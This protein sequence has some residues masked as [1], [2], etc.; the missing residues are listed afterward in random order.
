MKLTNYM[1]SVLFK[2]YAFLVYCIPMAILFFC[3]VNAYTSN[4]KLSFFGILIIGFIVIAFANTLKKIFKYNIGLS[5]SAVMF[6]V[7]L[8]SKFLGEQLILI[9]GASFVGSVLSM[10]VG[11]IANT[12]YRFA[13]K[14][15]EDG[16]KRKD[17]S[18]ALTL[19]E[20]WSETVF[21][22]K[23]EEQ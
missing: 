6:V 7:A 8:L 5:V 19:K 14:I 23:Y 2:L 20:A 17:R 22:F 10:V 11:E 15:D 9:S 18:R 13:F 16:R 21:S 12:Y 4:A 3:N 1:Q